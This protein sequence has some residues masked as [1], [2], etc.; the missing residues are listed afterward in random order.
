MKTESTHFY[1][2]FVNRVMCCISTLFFSIHVDRLM[3]VANV[4]IVYFMLVADFLVYIPLKMVVA[5][6]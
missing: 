5:N 2:Y 1:P 6:L 4:V 3:I